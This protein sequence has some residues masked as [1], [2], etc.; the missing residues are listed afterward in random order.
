PRCWRRSS[1]AFRSSVSA[2]PTRSPAG[3][4]SWSRTTPASSPARRCRSTAGSTCTEADG[5]RRRTVMEGP[6]AVPA[7]AAPSAPAAGR[8]YPAAVRVG[9]GVVVWRGDRVLL[10][11]RG[12]PPRQGEWGLPGGG[13]EL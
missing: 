3:S 1:P 8:E 10:V 7:P 13:Q 12:R 11:R 9:V 2:G 6:E 5:G 4:P